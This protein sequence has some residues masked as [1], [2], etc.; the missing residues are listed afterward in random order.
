MISLSAAKRKWNVVRKI[1][2]AAKR[3]K[4]KHAV[5]LQKPVKTD[6]AVKMGFAKREM[7]NAA[8][9]NLKLAANMKAK[10]RKKISAV[11]K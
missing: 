4:V 3:E 2:I 5:Q 10:K 1:R 6:L 11:S 8:K 7:Q 9:K